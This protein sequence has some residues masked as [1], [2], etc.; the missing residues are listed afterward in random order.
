MKFL[1][2]FEGKTIL[3][4]GG[5]GSIGSEIVSQLL[6]YNPKTI[7][8]LSN[9]ENELWKTKLEFKQYEKKLRFLLG[10]I[11]NYERI[12]RAVEDVDIVF[13]AA[14]IKHVPI[15]EYNPMEAVNV[16]IH[17]LENVIEAAFE[18]NV[19]KVIHIST[20]KAVTPTTVMGATKM[21]GE[22]LCISRALTKGHHVTKISCVRFGNVLGSRGSIIPLLKKQIESGNTVTLTDEKMMRF[23]L[24]ISQAVG[25]VL[26]AAGLAQGGE[27]FVLK[28]P[29]VRIKDLIEVII[30]EYAPKIGKDP[31]SIKIETIGPRLGEKIHEELIS[32]IEFSTVYEIEDMYCVYP[33]DF[34]G[35][36]IS[37]NNVID[38]TK[39]ISDK[40]KFNYSTE[41]ITP[42][43]KKEI[44]VLIKEYNLL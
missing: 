37:N 16:N 29:V 12:K 11:R 28:M 38:G 1:K 26:K 5:T 27:I 19:E 43:T 24:S 25:L 10:D 13:N 9:S 32:S 3:V 44:S 6:N 7:R 18:C 20:D 31:S 35:K 39:I 4:L 33:F 22:R 21:L 15:S 30:E 41:N 14:A 34:F 17:G 23:F 36:T 40:E 42:L 8:V 2:F